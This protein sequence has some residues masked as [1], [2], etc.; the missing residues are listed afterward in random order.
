LTS[1]TSHSDV[2]VDGDFSSQGLIKRGASSGSY[3]IVTDNSANWDLAY[4]WGD[5]SVAGYLTSG[6]AS[7]NLK[8]SNPTGTTSSGGVMMGLGS[9]IH[10]A[11]TSSGIIRFTI[12]GVAYANGAGST[13]TVTVKYGTGTAPINGAVPAG[14]TIG[15]ASQ[16][17][18]SG[19]A[20]DNRLWSK[21]IILTGLSTSTTYWFDVMITRAGTSNTVSISGVNATL[22]E[23][24]Q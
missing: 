21:N 18:V 11:P 1:E 9:T 12:D 19:T 2:V 8:P 15:V 24:C 16:F 5:H 14:T 10:F 13:I 7:V 22:E 20:G 23:L 3:S 6:T 4:G 17:A